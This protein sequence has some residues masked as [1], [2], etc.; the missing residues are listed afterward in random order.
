MVGGV[1][2]GGALGS[3]EKD[4]SRPFPF[5]TLTPLPP[6]PQTAPCSLPSPWGQRGA[7]LEGG[8][9]GRRARH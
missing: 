4:P 6:H 9:G 5:G 1:E 2:K 3:K 8:G 7:V